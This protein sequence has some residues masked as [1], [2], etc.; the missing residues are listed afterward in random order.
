HRERDQPDQRGRQA[1]RR[2]D[3][4]GGA[5]VA[6]SGPETSERGVARP[7]GRHVAPRP[8]LP[9]IAAHSYTSRKRRSTAALTMFMRSVMRKSVSPTAKMVLYS[10]EPNGASPRLIWTM[11]AV[12]VWML[13]SGFS[14]R[15]GVEPAAIAT[16]IVSPIARESASRK[17]AMMPESAAGTTVRVATSYFVAP[18]A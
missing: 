6:Q 11:Y 1:R 5:P 2:E 3:D 16:A 4:P 7:C 12:M 9:C 18:S 17:D 10:T 15:F 13:S 14:V 8:A